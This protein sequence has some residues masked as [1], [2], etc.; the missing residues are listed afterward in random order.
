MIGQRAGADREREQT[1]QGH[2]QADPGKGEHPQCRHAGGH[3]E[4][5]HD[6]V[7]R[8]PDQRNNA[9]KNRCIRQGQQQ[10]RR[11]NPA[12]PRDHAQQRPD[13]RRIVEKRRCGSGHSGQAQH[14]AGTAFATEQQ[15]REAVQQGRPLEHD[16]DQQQ[17]DQ[18]RQRRIG[19][20]HEP[21]TLLEQAGK[22]VSAGKPREQHGR[23]NPAV[24]Q[25]AD[26]H[27]DGGEY[28]V[29]RH[30]RKAPGTR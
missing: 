6:E 18:R 23:C 8:S 25:Q 9:P 14:R 27:A 19:I 2:R 12:L 7:G 24:Y 29:G 26:E 1:E 4:G 21:D 30:R 28:Q 15:I 17:Q 5:V 20:A 10:P 11:R 22:I 3:H 13:H 16:R